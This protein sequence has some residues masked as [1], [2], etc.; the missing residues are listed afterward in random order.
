MTFGDLVPF[1]PRAGRRLIIRRS[2]EPACE[3]YGSKEPYHSPDITMR[4]V[5]GCLGRS[6]WRDFS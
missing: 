4:K 6:I 3:E 5:C 2:C 1:Q